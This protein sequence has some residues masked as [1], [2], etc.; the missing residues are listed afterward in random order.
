M[1]STRF[2]FT[3]AIASLGLC[4]CGMT[5]KKYRSSV[6]LPTN[7]KNA[8]RFPV[9]S[10]PE[11]LSRWWS[12]FEDATLTR[13]IAA[14]WAANPDLASST[15]RVQE[16]RARRNSEA[17]SLFPSVT[18]STAANSSSISR[19]GQGSDSGTAFSANLTAAWEADL[20]G[21]NRSTIQAATAQLGASEEN[22]HSVQASLASEIAIAYTNL[23]VAESALGVLQ[24]TVMTRGETSEL[25]AWRTQSGVAD[26]LESAQALTSLEQARAA[27]PTLFQTIAQ[28]RNLLARLTGQAPGSLDALLD[29]GKKSIP[30]PSSSL[31][32]GIPADTLRQRPD[33]RLA[34]YQ[35][36][37]AAA[38][39]RAVAAT[40]YPA[41]NLTGSLGMNALSSGK[42]FNPETATAGVIAGLTGPIFNAGRIRAN[43]DAQNAV[44]EQAYQTYRAVVLTSLS[45][46]ENALIA[47]RRS[48]ERLETLEKA[49][50]A[51]REAA[52]LAQQ[53]YKAGVTDLLTVLDT[54]RTLLALEDS[55]FTTRA[56][57]TI[58]FIQLYRSLGGGWS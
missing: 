47:C 54:Q 26:S 44:E 19:D 45:E 58:A 3:A 28:N 39:S 51:A 23:R 21:K 34:G 6:S 4:G 13:V 15:A 25:A 37:A 24:R 57:R 2:F 11:D 1:T 55:L 27:I 5:A 7:W 20:F 49:T 48:T 29:S 17:A 35:L 18:G 10:G 14:A 46:V 36:L 33:V 56:N 32:L 9:A 30:S 41:L 38:T 12:R 40:R 31:A 50:A 53:R 22:F 52:A 16:A 8:N 42:I 43:I